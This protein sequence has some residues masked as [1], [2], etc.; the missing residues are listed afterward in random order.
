[1]YTEREVRNAIGILRTNDNHALV[2]KALG[3]LMVS[4]RS[5]SRI[6]LY[7]KEGVD[8]ISA[9]VLKAND[10]E[11]TTLDALLKLY[12]TL[13]GERGTKTT[14][15]AMYENFF[16]SMLLTELKSVCINADLAKT[17]KPKVETHNDVVMDIII[18][19]R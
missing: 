12:F 17:M 13:E 16:N 4:V 5:L 3:E 14:T 7:S 1:M 9:L 11:Y 6:M 18:A 19:I 10:G 15:L 2:T 8:S